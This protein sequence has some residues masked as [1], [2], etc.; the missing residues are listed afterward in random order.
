[1]MTTLEYVL[2][3]KSIWLNILSLATY[4]WWEVLES[5]CREVI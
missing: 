2:D 1:M 4:V 5:L 3:Q